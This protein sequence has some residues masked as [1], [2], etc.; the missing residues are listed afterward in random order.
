M[1]YNDLRLGLSETTRVK[2]DNS[3]YLD[4]CSLSKFNE[5]DEIYKNTKKLITSQT[6]FS[7]GGR[8]DYFLSYAT[9]VEEVEFTNQE[10]NFKILM[11]I[12]SHTNIKKAK[13]DAT[14]LHLEGITVS[15]DEVSIN[16]DTFKDI[17]VML[18]LIEKEGI[19][20]TVE[21]SDNSRIMDLEKLAPY[22]K[23]L[24]LRE[25]ELTQ[26]DLSKILDI[27]KELKELQ[28][29]GCRQ[30]Q[31]IENIEQYENLSLAKLD[32]RDLLEIPGVRVI[33]SD[34]YSYKNRNKDTMIIDLRKYNGTLIRLPRYGEIKYLEVL[35]ESKNSLNDIKIEETNGITEL[36]IMNYDD[37]ANARITK[38]TEK[39]YS[40]FKSLIG[41]SFEKCDID[42]KA[43]SDLKNLE[44][45]SI[46]SSNLNNAELRELP[47]ICKGLTSITINNCRNLTDVSA[48]AQF[49]NLGEI[50]VSNNRICRGIDLLVNYLPINELIAINNLITNNQISHILE[51]YNLT[52]I[53]LSRNPI[54]TFTIPEDYEESIN[55][56][57]NEC[58]LS[59]LKIDN[60]YE[61]RPD[62]RIQVRKEKNIGTIIECD[63]N[64][65][66]DPNK[67]LLKGSVNFYNNYNKKKE[68]FK[69]IEKLLQ[70]LPE[71]QKN[72][73]YIKACK[74][75]YNIPEN[76]RIDKESKIYSAYIGT[77]A[78]R[79]IVCIEDDFYYYDG[80]EIQPI[81]EKNPQIL[82]QDEK[83]QTGIL[84]LY[85]G[86]EIKASSN[87]IINMYRM[88]EDKPRKLE[89][90][91][92]KILD[93][94]CEEL[95]EKLPES[96]FISFMD[97][98]GKTINMIE[99]PKQID[100]ANGFPK[101]EF[102][103]NLF[104]FSFGGVR[105]KFINQDGKIIFLNIPNEITPLN[106]ESIELRKKNIATIKELINDEH[107]YLEQATDA[108]I[109]IMEDE[110]QEEKLISFLT[111]YLPCKREEIISDKTAKQELMESFNL[112]NYTA[113]LTYGQHI[114][115]EVTERLDELRKK[116][117]DSSEVDR[118]SS[119]LKRLNGVVEGK[120]EVSK[121]EK[122]KG[123]F[124]SLF[125]RK[126]EEEEYD[127]SDA[128][129]QSQTI[130]QIKEELKASAANI[131][132]S[133]SNCKLVQNITRDYGEKLGR[134]IQVAKDKL[135]E[136]KLCEANRDQIE[137]LERKIQ[138]LE[139]SKVL[140]QQTNMQFD[141][142]AKTKANL[143]EK[144]CTATQLIPI[145][146]SQSILR[147]NLDSQNDILELN[148]NMYKYTQNTII[149]N[150]NTLKETTERT[151]SGEDSIEILRSVIKSVDEI[152]KAT[153]KGLTSVESTSNLSI[154]MSEE[155]SEKNKEIETTI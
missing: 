126:K 47:K 142:V 122:K 95:R 138:S 46:D 20:V 116:M 18:D 128:E 98:E 108:D 60:K 38:E 110:A 52:T 132:D 74:K 34:F 12:T 45:L 9:A 80:N 55:I 44:T 130:E 150:A 35:L 58:L 115:Q 72:I 81:I 40:K 113:I 112:S 102:E 30:I 10:L 37:Q 71:E 57:L 136:L 123:F 129:K 66:I 101:K 75:Y 79:G 6:G 139:V 91:D 148:E 64:P 50:D 141:L 2:V 42:F 149:S 17:E 27:A 124:Q 118:V 22:I 83:R 103:M 85:L 151:L 92:Q 73:E 39:F 25:V 70:D 33:N 69:Q 135:E 107:F 15:K 11:I 120:E 140:A 31:E 87:K 106:E 54:T 88:L 13:F 77:L 1:I 78:F 4:N 97:R 94:F 119:T 93:I 100:I 105:I 41:I 21:I 53:N 143:F 63:N 65:L 99:L 84:E 7:K 121:P 56:N 133:I 23:G 19:D 86:E 14:E 24:R 82:L 48:L 3:L 36:Q 89:F 61:I 153:K 28:I 96:M 49:K 127:N 147:L 111:A 43:F 8:L 154:E 152:A 32:G 146:T 16:L 90:E 68:I 26:E 5:H 131:I 134:Y 62:G 125:R 114:Q 137:M 144:V 29:E 51:S 117:T 67:Y 76:G 59:V 155:T 104:K 145:L 109:V